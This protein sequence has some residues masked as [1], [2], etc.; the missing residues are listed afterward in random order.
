LN[1]RGKSDEAVEH[2]KKALE[3]AVDRNDNNL[4][5]AIRAQMKRIGRG[6]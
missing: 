2:F 5:D 6:N 3:L 4:A 1:N